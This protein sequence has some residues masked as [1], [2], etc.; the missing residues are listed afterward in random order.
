[1][2]VIMS[3]YRG[4]AKHVGFCACVDPIITRGREFQVYNMVESDRENVGPKKRRASLKK[5]WKTKSDLKQTNSAH[6]SEWATTDLSDWLADYNS[7][8]PDDKC[9]EEILLP[10][11]SKKLSNK[12]LR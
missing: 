4:G 9:S 6:S 5:P 11:C 10:S 2:G 1:M 3:L 7:R 12:W 8:N